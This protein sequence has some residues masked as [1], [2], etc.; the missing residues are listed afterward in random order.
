MAYEVTATRKRPRSFEQIVGQEFVVATLRG[1]IERQQI[2]HA[3]LFSG[4]RGVGK[5]SAARVL[6][7]A[8][9]CAAGPTVSACGEC[10]QC[11][12]IG[13]GSSLDVIE[14]DGASNTGVDDVRAIKD[15]V[16]FP[17]VAARYKVYIIDEVHMLST[18]A[19]NALL[20]TVEEPPPYVVF[21][22]A[23]TEIHKVPATIRSRCQQ[24]TFRLFSVDEIRDR[25]AEVAAEMSLEA[26]EEALIWVAK[27]ADGSLRDAYTTFDQIASFAGDRRIGIDA[28]RDTIGALSMDELNQVG[29]L[30]GSDDPAA[31]LT[32]ADEIMERGVSVERFV[33]AL[34]DYLRSLL[35]LR[36]GVT[37]PGI[38]GYPEASFNA[39]ARAR[40]SVSQLELA[41]ELLLEAHRNLKQSVSPRFEL[42]LLLSRLARVTGMVTPDEL[43]AE[44]HA[45]KDQFTGDG[46]D[47]GGAPARRPNEV[48]PGPRGGGRWAGG[49]GAAAAAGGTPPPGQPRARATGTAGTAGGPAAGSMASRGAASSTA[50]PDGAVRGRGAAGGAAASGA[51]PSSG[52]PGDAAGAG[53]SGAAPGGAASGGAATA[54]AAP[55]GAVAG[56]VASSATVAGG[57]VRSDAVP[58][59]AAPEPAIP[60]RGRPVAQAA[61][62][63]DSG[64]GGRAAATA[65]V[66]GEHATRPAAGAPAAPGDAPEVLHEIGARVRAQNQ[67]SL[68]A[69]VERAQAAVVEAGRVTVTFAASDRYHGGQVAGAQ[70]TLAAVASEI[71]GRPVSVGVDYQREQGREAADA[72][73]AAP[74]N[75][76]VGRFCKIFRGEVIKEITHGI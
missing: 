67:M 23:T 50:F 39:D 37:R 51:A 72:R 29:T 9:N 68:A 41:G 36:H 6:A 60:P 33:I 11:K 55:G 24:F 14:I 16:L 47:A 43:L 18:S 30:I 57:P 53:A 66:A 5:T 7:R 32:L 76:D 69:S 64:N 28:I 13:A 48:A 56:G 27:E 10:N 73:A 46:G 59:G 4:P 26:D 21:I 35:L 63:R 49:G 2:A 38:L 3:F 75:V 61:V 22:F 1:A 42:E 65:E 62:M 25:L 34:A 74:E 45:I 20:K 58:G 17:P 44:V 71:L 70:Q 31:M 54:G 19:F 15:E 52:T 12:E 8:L 40:L